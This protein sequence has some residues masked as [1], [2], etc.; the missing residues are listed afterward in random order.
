MMNKIMG[1]G[2]LFIGLTLLFWVLGMAFNMTSLM[3]LFVVCGFI[4][5]ILSIISGI[6]L[7]RESRE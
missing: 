2:M 7:F 1:L 6:S 4:G 3:I 5:A